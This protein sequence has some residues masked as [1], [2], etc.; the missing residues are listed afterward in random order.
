MGHMEHPPAHGSTKALVSRRD[1]TSYLG[2]CYDTI[3]RMQ[4]RGEL[5]TIPVGA[6]Q[7]IPLCE[8]RAIAARGTG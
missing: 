6:R 8:L 4:R 2:V 3:R 1:A 7:Q 5:S